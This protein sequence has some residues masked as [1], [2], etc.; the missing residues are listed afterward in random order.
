MALK[1]NG[2]T[3]A[4]ISSSN[5]HKDCLELLIQHKADV[6][7]A[8]NVSAL[9]FVYVL[10]MSWREKKIQRH[11]VLFHYF[12]QFFFGGC[13]KSDEYEIHRCCVMCAAVYSER[14]RR[15]CEGEALGGGPWGALGG[16][17]MQTV[18]SRKPPY[19]IHEDLQDSSGK[20]SGKK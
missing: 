17:V 11:F 16:G 9:V 14:L 8:T 10:P 5:G 2:R 3:P 15:N 6:N 12:F 19:K 4:Y 20:G 1:Q 18:C 13:S 7:K